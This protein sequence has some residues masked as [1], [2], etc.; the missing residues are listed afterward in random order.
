ME[1]QN[2]GRMDLWLRI[3]DGKLVVNPLGG[4][5]DGETLDFAES[6]ITCHI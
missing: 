5:I 1:Q 2:V 6:C 4:V 3:I